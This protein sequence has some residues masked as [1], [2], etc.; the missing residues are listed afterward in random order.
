MN[1]CEPKQ[2]QD[3]QFVLN[4][5]LIIEGLGDQSSLLVYIQHSGH[6]V[7]FGQYCITEEFPLQ[8]QKDQGNYPELQH[9]DVKLVRCPWLK[10]NAE[11][12]GRP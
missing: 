7:G 2:S 12:C 8:M 4:T 6:C 11:H 1:H 9:V 10:G 3:C 5:R